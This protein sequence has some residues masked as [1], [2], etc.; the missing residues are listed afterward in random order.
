MQAGLALRAGLAISVGLAI[1]VGLAL[2][3]ACRIEVG[4]EE[5]ASTSPPPVAMATD[6][7]RAAC[8]EPLPKLPLPEPV[9]LGVEARRLLAAG[10]G[11]LVVGAQG[12]LHRHAE[13][14][15]ERLLEGGRDYA[16]RGERLVRLE[17]D[18]IEVFDYRPTGVPAPRSKLAAQSHDISIALLERGAFVHSGFNR[19][20]LVLRR[21]IRDGTVVGALLPVERDLLRT[22][23]LGPE[24]LHEDEGI[25]VASGT[26]LLHVPLVG[27]PVQAVET[28]AGRR[29]VLE[30]ARGRRGKVRFDRKARR[31]V[32]PCPGCARRVEL[33]GRDTV[34]PLYAGA[35]VEDGVFWILRLDPAGAARAALLRVAAH[36]PEVRA[37]RLAFPTTPGALAVWR[38]SLA[39]AAGPD[40]WRM[41]LPRPESGIRCRA[42]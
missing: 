39:I 26:W 21:S 30:L 19:R 12:G 18:R 33:R 16:L 23:L 15:T 6:T 42:Q 38:D 22:L 36:A 25:L 13:G 1:P 31:D 8:P 3:T 7:L 5:V 37:W 9:D 29:L 41:P 20:A 28:S 14:R 2:L 32:Q 27:D 35:A 17:E 24:R 34:V 40:L 11:L 10:D 4:G